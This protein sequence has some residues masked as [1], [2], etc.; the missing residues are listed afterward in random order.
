[1]SLREELLNIEQEEVEGTDREEVLS[2]LSECSEKVVFI[3]RNFLRDGSVE[4][5]NSCTKWNKGWREMCLS[6]LDSFVP[7]A[8]ETDAST[9]VGKYTLF[10]MSEMQMDLA[11]M[12]K[13]WDEDNFERIKDGGEEKVLNFFA[14][15]VK[16]R[17]ES[18]YWLSFVDVKME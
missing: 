18:V 2:I 15:G 5:L 17:L 7:R 16:E 12:M 14:E 10:C 11:G 4:C 8:V 6:M 13:D 9:S 1:M 3:L